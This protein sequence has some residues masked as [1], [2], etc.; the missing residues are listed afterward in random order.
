[1]AEPMS[2]RA[3]LEFATGSAIQNMGR[4][5]AAF[6]QLQT[7][8]KKVG[9]G[10][11][12]VGGSITRLG[13]GF[14]PLTFAMGL[15]V[16][17]AN[18]FERGIAEVS[19]IAD[20]AQMPI[21]WM[22][23]ATLGL[24]VQ[25]GTFPV[26]QTK[27]LYQAVSSGATE[28]GQAMDFLTGANQLAIAGISDTATSL[29]LLTGAVQLFGKSGLDGA[30]AAD[31]MFK[32]VQ[33]G[34]TTIPELGAALGQVMPT[35]A[36]LGIRFEEL[37][38]AM[39][40]VTLGNINTAEA[41]TG[42]N[43]AFANIIKPSKEATEVAKKLGIE[44]TSTALKS[45]GLTKFMGE[46]V[47]KAGDDEIALSKLF[48]SIRGS[49]AIMTLAANGAETYTNN[50]AAMEERAGAAEAAFQKM[51]KTAD[52]QQRRLFALRKVASTVFGQ[53][54]QRSLLRIMAPLA[55]V[56]EG[57]VKILQAVKSGEFQGLSGTAKSIALGIRDGMDAIRDGVEM[58]I[59]KFREAKQW[60]LDTFG[61][62]AMR[63]IAKWGTIFVVA[64]AA[65]APL[66]LAF[67]GLGFVISSVGGLIMGLGTVLGG[68]FTIAL[69][70]IGVLIGL[71]VLFWDQF[72]AMLTGIMQVAGPVFEDLKG[73]FFDIV[74]TIK[75]AFADLTGSNNQATQGISADWVEVGRVIGAALGAVL[76][77]VATV[78]Q[79]VIKFAG[80]AIFAFRKWGEYLG[81]FAGMVVTFVMNPLKHIA[82]GVVAFMKFTGMKVPASLQDYAGADVKLV[83][84][85]GPSEMAGDLARQQREKTALEAKKAAGE[86]ESRG[87]LA[88]ILDEVAAAA[89]SAA[90][91][92]KSA[93]DA[94]KKKPCAQVNLDGREVGRSVS[95]AQE[96]INARDGKSTHWQRRRVL[97]HGAVPVGT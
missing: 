52:F 25:F 42:L 58:V 38:S 50:I 63:D 34:K 79:G 32:T 22:E 59:Q 78:V 96:S 24:A 21:E 5:S 23:K 91:G 16:R 26:E 62:T 82:K 48:G 7:G 84:K 39:A 64:A 72:S 73:I 60:V 2:I 81:T 85:R 90:D 89:G 68:V 10:V 6:Q 46:I 70:P 18:E 4:A 45:K 37:G 54:L 80:M 93:A 19:T 36:L 8:A 86:E 56:A 95:K 71:V 67:A 3:I 97:E 9:S 57:F 43:A 53:V 41:A 75:L 87:A 51:S 77:T 35:A 40:A 88:G 94:A 69:G 83:R 33:L 44:F 49:K 14:A 13:M 12:Q 55:G 47:D 15:A 31:V 76:K 17:D 29:D 61:P 92:A 27:S 28:A 11:S 20:S 30:D 74:D 66:L 1:M 65:I